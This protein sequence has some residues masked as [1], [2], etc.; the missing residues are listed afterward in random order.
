MKA[1]DWCRNTHTGRKRE[2]EAQGRAEGGAV[3]GL[4]GNYAVKAKEEGSFIK[5]EEHGIQCCTERCYIPWVLFSLKSEV[6]S[7][8]GNSC[9]RGLMRKKQWTEELA[10]VEIKDL[11]EGEN[12]STQE[13]TGSNKGL[14][15]ETFLK[16][17]ETTTFTGWREG[18]KSRVF[19]ERL[20]MRG[21]DKGRRLQMNRAINKARSQDPRREG[22]GLRAQSEG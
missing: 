13:Q 3:R 22:T 11:W 10:K 1:N 19:S 14:W 9:F 5:I 16:I 7:G 18:A 12:T 20:K 17:R 21:K 15:E 8:L 4:A 2:K 6:T